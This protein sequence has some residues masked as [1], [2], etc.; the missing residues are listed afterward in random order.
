M[1]ESTDEGHVFGKGKL[2]DET[3]YRD[4]VNFGVGVPRV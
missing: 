4:S 2:L 3:G 1:M